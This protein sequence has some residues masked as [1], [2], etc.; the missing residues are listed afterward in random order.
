MQFILQQEKH[1]AK[2]TACKL[3]GQ[4]NVVIQILL[5]HNQNTKVKPKKLNNWIASTCKIAR[6]KTLNQICH[7]V[8]CH[9]VMS[10]GSCCR[11]RIKT[12]S[13]LLFLR[14]STA[15]TYNFVILLTE[16]CSPRGN[17]GL[18]PRKFSVLKQSTIPRPAI[19]SAKHQVAGCLPCW[20][21]RPYCWLQTCYELSTT[22]NAQPSL[23][24]WRADW[25]HHPLWPS[26]H[27]CW[28]HSGVHYLH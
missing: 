2:A 4:E 15:S 18:R 7:V 1:H 3:K 20:L 10:S 19:V 26:C 11:V 21:H 23:T 27:S 14:T 8:L 22:I 12:W 16:P 28:H 13:H 5:V 17:A 6:M 24:D 9:G 25:S